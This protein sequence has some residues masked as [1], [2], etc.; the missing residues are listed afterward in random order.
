MADLLINAGANPKTTN[1][2][3]VTPLYLKPAP[4]ATRR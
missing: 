2:Y 3:G 1:A 4:T